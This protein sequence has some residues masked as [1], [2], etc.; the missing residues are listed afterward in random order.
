MCLHLVDAMKDVMM[1]IGEV[2]VGLLDMM[3]VAGG[4]EM[5]EEVD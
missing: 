5:K 3:I 1:M 4:V 2:I